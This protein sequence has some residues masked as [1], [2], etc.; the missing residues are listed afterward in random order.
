VNVSKPTK[1]MVILLLFPML[2]IILTGCRAASASSQGD[3]KMAAMDGMPGEVKS[4]KPQVQQAYQFAFANQ[5]L[6]KH[7][8]CYCGCDDDA[9]KSSYDCYI[10]NVD[11]QG[12]ITYDPHALDCKIC[13]DI[14]HD[15]MRLFKQ[16]KPIPEIKAYIDQSYSQYGPSNMP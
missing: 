15:V 1:V 5:D 6:M 10:T 7:I 11:D 4:A 2:F 3:L 12:R 16:G 14:T 13:V 9:H 8:P